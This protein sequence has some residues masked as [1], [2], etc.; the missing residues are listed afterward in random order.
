MPVGSHPHWHPPAQ[1]QARH[2]IWL[3][4]SGWVDDA[5]YSQFLCLTVAIPE[6]PPLSGLRKQ[7][8]AAS[9][10]CAARECCVVDPDECAL[11]QRWS[12]GLAGASC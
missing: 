1:R 10:P 7:C 3:P 6:H 4:T 9:Y 12:T 2:R 5:N 8:S 11:R